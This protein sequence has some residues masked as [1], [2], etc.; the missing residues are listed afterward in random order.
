MKVLSWYGRD[1]AKMVM[2]WGVLGMLLV[3]CDG[4]STGGGVKQDSAGGM[5]GYQRSGLGASNNKQPIGTEVGADSH[6]VVKV[7]EANEGSVWPKTPVMLVNGQPVSWRALHPVLVEMGGR[8]VVSDFVVDQQLRIELKKNDMVVTREDIERERKIFAEQLSVDENTAMKLLIEM[9]ERQGLGD[10]RF[11]MMMFRNAGLRKLVSEDVKVTEPMLHLA[12]QQAYGRRTGVRLLMVDT[13]VKAQTVVERLQKGDS[14]V[15]LVYEFSTDNAS[16]VQG[17][18]LPLI[19]VNDPEYPL[20]L[21][22]TVHR[23]KVGEVSLPISLTGGYAIVK[24]ERI[25]QPE[26]KDF[27]EV[28]DDLERLVRL[29]L[30]RVVMERVGRALIQKA[31]VTV[32]DGQLG[33][34]W[35]KVKQQYDVQE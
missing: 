1:Y 18:L 6:D 15:E 25:V 10:M 26:Q 14:F 23:M 32:L 34:A 13:L 8:Q 29:R 9:R 27:E 5:N 21:R 30:E 16:R 22:R 3:G 24:C 2:M 4:M 31:D 35:L 11:K 17:G 19:N 20:E 7:N 28:K 33:E 12:Y